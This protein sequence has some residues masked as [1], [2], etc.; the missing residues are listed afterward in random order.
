MVDELEVGVDIAHLDIGN[1]RL[2]ALDVLDELVFGEVVAQEHLVADR[3]DS[4]VAGP[5]DLDRVAQFD[6]VLLEIVRQPHTDHRLQAVLRGDRRD[7]FV[8]IGAEKVRI[9]RVYG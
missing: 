6:F 1:G 3:Q 5:G 8:P 4:G 9:Q 7:Q 2:D